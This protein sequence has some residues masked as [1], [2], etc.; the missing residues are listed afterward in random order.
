MFPP[1]SIRWHAVQ[2]FSDFLNNRIVASCLKWCF[3]Y[4]F[5]VFIFISGQKQHMGS[6]CCCC[7]CFFYLETNPESKLSLTS[8][9]IAWGL[10][11]SLWKAKQ[12]TAM[13]AQPSL[14]MW[15]WCRVEVDFAE[16]WGGKKKMRSRLARCSWPYVT[17]PSL[18]NTSSR[19]NSA[20]W[21]TKRSKYK[22]LHTF[23]EHI[24]TFDFFFFL[25]STRNKY[26]N[27]N[28]CQ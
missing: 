28:V 13:K 11:H 4:S 6:C 10:A 26:T 14:F 8:H 16:F 22:R 19:F 17:T 5:S 25:F 2:R 9:D 18:E 27:M 24:Q 1:S 12:A 3:Q 23:L 7:F 15:S 20:R 21:T